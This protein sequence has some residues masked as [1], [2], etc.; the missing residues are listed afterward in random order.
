MRHA[1]VAAYGFEEGMEADAEALAW[2]WEHWE[3]LR[4]VANR[5]GYRFRIA[6]GRRR[7]TTVQNHAA[8]Y[9]PAARQT[10]SER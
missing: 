7:Q 5:P 3:R 1:L 4:D 8:G 10:R 9:G 2:A 6:Q